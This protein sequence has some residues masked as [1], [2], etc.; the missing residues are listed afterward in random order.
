MK[1]FEFIQMVL[2]VAFVI[3]LPVAATSRPAG[4][5]FELT[6]SLLQAAKVG[7]ILLVLLGANF[8]ANRLWLRFRSETKSNQ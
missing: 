8:C 5:R 4:Q 2:I 7:A 1:V 6:Q 3:G